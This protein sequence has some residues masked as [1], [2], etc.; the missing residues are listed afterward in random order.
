MSERDQFFCEPGNYTLSST[1]QAGRDAFIKWRDLGNT[2]PFGSLEDP[3]S[4]YFA[5]IR[6]KPFI[7]KACKCLFPQ[8]L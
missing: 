2:H 3:W 7:G 6:S 8:Y 4:W 5:S 1:V